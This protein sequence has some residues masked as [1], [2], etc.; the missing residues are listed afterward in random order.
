MKKILIV[1]LVTFQANAFAGNDYTE[2]LDAF[3]AHDRYVEERC[4][5]DAV[6][7]EQEKLYQKYRECQNLDLPNCE[8]IGKKINPNYEV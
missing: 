2:T 6:F 1:L 7:C 5:R 4:E 3:A 8:E